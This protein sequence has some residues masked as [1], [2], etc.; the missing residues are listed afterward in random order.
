MTKALSNIAVEYTNAYLS[1]VQNTQG[2]SVHALELLLATT[3][4]RAMDLI[5]R[6]NTAFLVAN[7]LGTVA[8]ADDKGHA[9]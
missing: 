5:G 9:H 3:I 1:E 8:G 4:I 6:E 7:A 2:D